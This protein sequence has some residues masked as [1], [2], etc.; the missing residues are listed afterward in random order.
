MSTLHSQ[1][2]NKKLA[3]DRC[4]PVLCWQTLCHFYEQQN[5]LFLLTKG[6]YIR[7]V[8]RRVPLLHS[9]ANLLSIRS[10]A[11]DVPHLIP[12]SNTLACLSSYHTYVYSTEYWNWEVQDTGN[13]SFQIGASSL[14]SYSPMATEKGSCQFVARQ[15]TGS[16]QLDRLRT[17]SSHVLAMGDTIA[18]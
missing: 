6:T 1:Q 16:V 5:D 17:R 18:A 3:V 15:P 11:I 8:C 14:V 10:T 13:D 4:G 7:D 12:Y 2:G 9:V